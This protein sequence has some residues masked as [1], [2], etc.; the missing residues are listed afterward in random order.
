MIKTYLTMGGTPKVKFKGSNK[1]L[2]QD[3]IRIMWSMIEH[4]EKS[5]QALVDA[6]GE[7][8]FAVKHIENSK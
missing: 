7:I 3:L 2:K 8:N 6:I 1:V 4:D 5:R